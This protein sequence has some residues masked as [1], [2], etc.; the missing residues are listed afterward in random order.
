MKP[1]QIRPFLAGMVMFG[2]V[3]TDAQFPQAVV[4]VFGI[5]EQRWMVTAERGDFQ[6]HVSIRASK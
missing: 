6:R 4:R 1:S 3:P 2:P 5:G